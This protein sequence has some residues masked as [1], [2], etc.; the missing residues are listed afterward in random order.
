[1]IFIIWTCFSYNVTFSDIIEYLSENLHFL[2]RNFNFSFHND[3]KE[4]WGSERNSPHLLCVFMS[5]TYSTY[6]HWNCCEN[7]HPLLSYLCV[8]CVLLLI[9]F[10][11][12]CFWD[13]CVQYTSL[14]LCL[15]HHPVSSLLNYIISVFTL[16]VE[17]TF[18][19]DSLVSTRI[20]S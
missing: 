13:V 15:Q 4:W 8:T 10:S 1:M 12:R 11:S 17:F 14:C 16:R 7:L 3:D 5:V 9:V 19:F 2:Y 6:R 20:A 18:T